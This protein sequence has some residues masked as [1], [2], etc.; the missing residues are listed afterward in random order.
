MRFDRTAFTIIDVETT[1]LFAYSGDKICEIGALRVEPDGRMDHF[2]TL[3]DP[4]RYISSGAFAVNG[5]T[6]EML[7][8]QPKIGEVMPALLDFMANSVIVA[9]NA[10][11]DLGFIECALGADRWRLKDFLAIDALKVARRVFPGLSKYSLKNVANFLKIYPDTEHRAM[12]DVMTTWKVFD[13]EVEILREKGVG[14]I[15][16]IAFPFLS[17][18]TFSADPQTVT[19]ASV[20]RAAINTGSAISIKYRSMWDEK[21]TERVISPISLQ[22]GY[23]SSYVVAFCHLRKARR[24]F[25]LKNIIEASAI[26]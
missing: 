21:V 5:I 17:D 25:H 22:D 7:H 15:T 23:D 12:A 18:R 19:I 26:R 11:F 10:P 2:E 20:I 24:N 6:P 14:S 9:Y 4:E 3:V 1:G 13:R 8:G 16:D